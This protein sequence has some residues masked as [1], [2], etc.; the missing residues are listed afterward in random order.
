MG[1]VGSRADHS[2]R[3]SGPRQPGRRQPVVYHFNSTTF[4]P[5]PRFPDDQGHKFGCKRAMAHAKACRFPARL[6]TN[7]DASALCYA[8]AGRDGRRC[9]RDRTAS[10]DRRIRS[11][12]RCTSGGSPRARSER[13]SIGR[14]VAKRN[15]RLPQRARAR[16]AR[17]G[18]QASRPIRDA[19]SLRL[20][21]RPDGARL[22]E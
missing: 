11:R 2:T 5:N 14:S 15:A 20:V 22:H 1:R 16:R 9:R 21:Q 4:P 12:A 3:P 6:S 19:K 7:R 13:P 10:G 17:R 18:P 8:R